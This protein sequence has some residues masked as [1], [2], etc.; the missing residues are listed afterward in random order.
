[1]I[2]G[3]RASLVM[4]TIVCFLLCQAG[5]VGASQEPVPAS[6]PAPSP[7]SSTELDETTKLDC[8]T[9]H[10]EAQIA[11]QQRRLRDARAA[12]RLCSHVACPRLI[13]AD[14]VDWLD[15]VSRSVPSV[16]V[17]AR[18]RG[19]DLT[20]VRVLVDGKPV[21]ARLSGGAMDLDPGEHTFRFE[22]PPWTPVERTLL[23]S[24]GVKG[25][26]IDV[27]FAP[28]AIATSRLPWRQRLTKFDYVV[29]S[30]GA[31]ALVA[32]ASLGVWAL[33][34]RH[35]M[36]VTCAPFCDHDDVEGV[37]ARLALADVAL[38]V[39]LISAGIIW[40]HVAFPADGAVT[41]GVRVA[42]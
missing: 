9:H 3:G 22:A 42:F 27:E 21:A 29:G 40:L 31:A 32:S 17:T 11:R 15:Q 19:L 12:L 38:G 20:E 36:R 26:P 14:C 13:R 18:A 10:E 1:V 24:E 28:A 30:I 23:I 35:D 5:A 8:I 34:L 33:W 7:V 2:P 6:L 4:A 25:R 37:R 16:V 41:V 39:A